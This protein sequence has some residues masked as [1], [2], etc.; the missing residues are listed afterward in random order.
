ML[1]CRAS[2]WVSLLGTAAFAVAPAF[3]AHHEAAEEAVES[4]CVTACYAT[5]DSCS[6]ACPTL[7]GLQEHCLTQCVD[8]GD[9]C[10]QKCPEGGGEPSAE[11]PLP[12]SP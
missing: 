2:T 7:V 6:A 3:A 5:E 12:E 8:T 4:Q 11:D 1:R 10:R 9:S